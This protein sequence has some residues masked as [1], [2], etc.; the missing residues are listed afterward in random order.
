[1]I[2]YENIHHVSLCVTDIERSKQFYG[3]LLGLIEVERPNFDFPGA[4]YQIGSSQ[5]HLIQNNGAESLR[6]SKTIDSRDGHFAIRVKSYEDTLQYLNDHGLKV[7]AK[8]NSKSGF[9]QI[10]CMDPDNN[11]IEFNVDQN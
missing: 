10:F 3:G 8:P 11:L 7:E 1:M 2:K 5:L 6:S 9:K 4:W